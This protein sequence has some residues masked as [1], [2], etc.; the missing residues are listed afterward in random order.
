MGFLKKLKQL[1]LKFPKASLKAFLEFKFLIMFNSFSKVLKISFLIL[2]I[3][4]SN[5]PSRHTYELSYRKQAVCLR[6][7]RLR[8]TIH[9]VFKHAYTCQKM[10]IQTNLNFSI[11]ETLNQR[12]NQ[13]TDSS[14]SSQDTRIIHDNL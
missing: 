11:S 2:N 10:S 7:P 12:M 13:E 5:Y 4:I 14:L 6:T 9:T 1:I 8:S 3:Y